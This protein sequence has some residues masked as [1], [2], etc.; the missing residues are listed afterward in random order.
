MQDLHICKSALLMSWGKPFIRSAVSAHKGDLDGR[1]VPFHQ[2]IVDGD[3]EVRKG[4]TVLSDNLLDFFRSAMLV[5]GDQFVPMKR[6]RGRKCL[7]DGRQIAFSPAIFIQ[8]PQD[9]FNLVGFHGGSLPHSK[10]FERP[11]SFKLY[12]DRMVDDACVYDEFT[13]TVLVINY[14]LES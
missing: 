1:F 3:L 7:I 12:L 14:G 8:P 2:D 5:G 11:V 9:C 13:S 4:R 6:V 10:L